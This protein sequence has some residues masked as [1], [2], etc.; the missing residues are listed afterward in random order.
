MFVALGGTGYAT[1]QLATHGDTT[2]DTTLFNKLAKKQILFATV[3]T[4]LSP[5]IARGRGATAVTNL[6]SDG[7]YAV[8]F[9]RSVANCTWVATSGPGN[10]SPADAV[11]AVVR[12][13]K[14]NPNQVQVNL[15]TSFSDTE[16]IGQGFHL[17]VLCP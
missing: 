12:G 1:T 9:N 8:T 11:L 2:P 4:G 17:M 5:T 10:A 7:E 3:K 15:F 13:V 6:D 16:F 14:S